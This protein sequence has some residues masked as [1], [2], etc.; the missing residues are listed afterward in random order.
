[1]SI[2][3]T[4]LFLT[5][6]PFCIKYQNN[7]P[8]IHGSYM[9]IIYTKL[10]GLGRGEWLPD[11]SSFLYNKFEENWQRLQPN[12]ATVITGLNQE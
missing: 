1:M 2:A 9:I 3:Y 4:S 10:I 12:T 11:Q 7:L 8:G 6:K 5:N